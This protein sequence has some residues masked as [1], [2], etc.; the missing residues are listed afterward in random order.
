MKKSFLILTVLLGF[1]LYVNAGD[2]IPEACNTYSKTFVCTVSAW[3]SNS[4]KT[5][6]VNIY[7]VKYG[8]SGHYSA[9]ELNSDGGESCFSG[10]VKFVTNHKYSGR[11]K[12][13]A[14]TG[15]VGALF[16]NSKRLDDRYV[17]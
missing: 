7:F 14:K 5:V 9:V 10:A 17:N 1:V 13:Y 15:F 8:D 2:K 3:D 16:F 4:D 6:K 12:Y 11:Y